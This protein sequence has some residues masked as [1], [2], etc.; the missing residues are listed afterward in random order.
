MQAC[1]TLESSGIVKLSRSHLVSEVLLKR[2][3]QG[4]QRLGDRAKKLGTLFLIDVA[5]MDNM[6]VSYC[7]D[8]IRFVKGFQ[9][10]LLEALDIRL[11]NLKVDGRIEDEI[12]WRA[13]SCFQKQN[14]LDFICH[15]KATSE[16]LFK[17]AFECLQVT[18]SNQFTDKIIW[19][20]NKAVKEKPATFYACSLELAVSQPNQFAET[21]PKEI[22]KQTTKRTKNQTGKPSKYHQESSRFPKTTPFSTGSS[23][24]AEKPS[25]SQ[26]KKQA[27]DKKE[28]ERTSRDAKITVFNP[29][30]DESFYFLRKGEDLPKNLLETSDDRQR[31]PQFGGV[32]PQE[33]SPTQQFLPPQS[34]LDGSKKH[35]DLMKSKANPG[36]PASYQRKT[37]DQSLRSSLRQA[38]RHLS[39]HVT[40]DKSAPKKDKRE[41]EAKKP[42]KKTTT[43]KKEPE[44]S[45]KKEEDS[46]WNELGS[47]QQLYKHMLSNLDAINT[48]K[49]SK[50]EKKPTMARNDVY[51]DIAGKSQKEGMADDFWVVENEQLKPQHGKIAL[52]FVDEANKKPPLAKT[53]ISKDLAFKLD[54]FVTTNYS[55]KF[56]HK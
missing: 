9:K 27:H 34:K 3:V 28:V 19:K 52:R 55:P 22:E 5:S 47:R 43:K 12:I 50:T 31:L 37:S 30:D 39:S 18:S 29:E 21:S 14:S 46:F 25:R 51:L 16:S 23:K 38:S 48:L 15:L 26:K 36:R 1:S 40:E 6:R 8:E 56:Y 53:V 4:G 13:R 17:D 7:L 49:E 32:N 11:A 45:I 35:Q 2:S 54:K 42:R 44:T 20:T 10:T 33:E 41:D 24:S